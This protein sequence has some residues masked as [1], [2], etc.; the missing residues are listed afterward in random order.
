MASEM[1]MASPMF[2]LLEGTFGGGILAEC[3][4][5]PET[6]RNCIVCVLR[7]GLVLNLGLGA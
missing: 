7:F 3:V 6:E 4:I 2:L 5:F 1:K